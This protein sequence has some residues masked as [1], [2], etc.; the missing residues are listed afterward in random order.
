MFVFC[1]HSLNDLVVVGYDQFFFTNY[2]YANAELE[3]LFELRWGSLGYFDGVRS[4]LVQTG[5]IFPN[6][7]SKS[8][9]GRLASSH[10]NYNF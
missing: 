2:Y 10:T 1:V 5:L 8:P 3:V 4:A 7:I 9:D 6:G